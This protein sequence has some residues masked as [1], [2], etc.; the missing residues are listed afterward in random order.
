MA[1]SSR[2]SVSG[3]SCSAWRSTSSSRWSSSRWACMETYSPVAIEKDPATRPARPARRTTV[4][5]GWAPATPR[6]RATLVT[7]PSLMPKT[8]ARAPPAWMSRWWWSWGSQRAALTTPERSDHPGAA[9]P[10]RL[11]AWPSESGWTP[12][13]PRRSRGR[14]CSPT[15]RGA[16][17]PHPPVRRAG[18]VP[19]AGPHGRRRL[20]HRQRTARRLP[21]RHRP[22]RHLPVRPGALLHPR[23]RGFGSLLDV[24]FAGLLVVLLLHPESRSYERVWFH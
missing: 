14:C 11:A 19:R 21:R 8:A 22:R 16:G 3:L 24:L 9:S 23:A 6:M 13:S 4:P 18:P 10:G 2:R 1:T 7:R 20:R 15:S 12:A 17:P 5:V